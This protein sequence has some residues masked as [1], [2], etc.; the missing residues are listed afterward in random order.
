MVRRI[1][2]GAQVVHGGVSLGN[3]TTLKSKGEST[4]TQ[5]KLN[6]CVMHVINLHCTFLH[7]ILSRTSSITGNNLGGLL[8]L[9]GGQSPRPSWLFLFVRL[10]V[11]MAL[12]RLFTLTGTPIGKPSRVC[13]FQLAVRQPDRRCSPSWRSGAQLTQLN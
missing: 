4:N 9:T 1:K 3:L 2:K 12:V 13:C 5:N 7:S 10:A 11:L 6:A 8:L